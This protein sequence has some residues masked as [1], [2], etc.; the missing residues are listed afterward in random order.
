M[1]FELLI[2][3]AY[4]AVSCKLYSIDPDGL[5]EYKK[6]R[7]QLALLWPV[8]M[9]IVAIWLIGTKGIDTFELYL[10]RG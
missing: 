7:T 6:E 8:V 5:R 9:V 2:V 1:S 10:K 4:L 3:A